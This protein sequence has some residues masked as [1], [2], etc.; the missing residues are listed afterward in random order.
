VPADPTVATLAGMAWE[1]A[2]G[3]A[4]PGSTPPG[5]CANTTAGWTITTRPNPFDLPSGFHPRIHLV[6]AAEVLTATPPRSAV[7]GT[8][9]GLLAHR[10]AYTASRR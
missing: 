9:T 7:A 3:P 10:F 4:R 2:S 8:L 1:P 5:P 6:A